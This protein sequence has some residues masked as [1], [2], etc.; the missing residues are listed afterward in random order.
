[1]I[2]PTILTF[3]YLLYI[4]THRQQPGGAEEMLLYAGEFG[5]DS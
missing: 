3:K 1:M 2:L 4:K 5:D